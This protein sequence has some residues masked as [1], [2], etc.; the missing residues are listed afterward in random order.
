MVRVQGLS[1]SVPI[2]SLN[3]DERKEVTLLLNIAKSTYSLLMD[4]LG[5]HTKPGQALYINGKLDT[6]TI[7]RSLITCHFR[8]KTRKYHIGRCVV[9]IDVAQSLAALRGVYL[10]I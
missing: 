9:D 4:S 6:S 3:D 5:D 7:S 1:S 8:C 2:T 10:L